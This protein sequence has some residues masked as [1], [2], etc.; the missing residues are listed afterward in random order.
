MQQRF[1]MYRWHV[2][3]P[4]SFDESLRVTI[5]DLG[6]RRNGRRYLARTDDFSSVAYWYQTL[7]SVPMKTLPSRDEMEVI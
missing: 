3:D 7:P 5:Q 2:C 4:V 1:S 6:W